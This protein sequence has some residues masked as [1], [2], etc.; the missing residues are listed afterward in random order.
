[1]AKP[2]NN[3]R[4]FKPK[5]RLAV[6]GNHELTIDAI[7]SDGRGIAKHK[8]KTVFVAGALPGEQ[9][10]V[11][12]TTNR[13]NHDEA[14][15]IK[16]LQAC[17]QRVAPP[18]QYYGRCGGCSF[19]H[20]HHEGQLQA[21]Q[22]H[23]QQLFKHHEQSQE[24]PIAWQPALSADAYHY[25]HRVRFAISAKGKHFMLGYRQANSHELIAID[26][27]A[28]ADPA[29]NTFLPTLKQLLSTL[30]KRALLLECAVA[31]DADKQ[32]SVLLSVKAELPEQDYAQLQRFAQPLAVTIKV[33]HVE[34]P[35]AAPLFISGSQPQRYRLSAD[36]N[37][38]YQAGDFTQINTAINQQMIQCLKSW[39]QL[40]EQDVVAD[41][42][43]GIGNL[44]LPMAAA[45]Q[46]LLAYELV[47]TMVAKAQANAADNGLTNITFIVADLFAE[48]LVIAQ[49]ANKVVL[50][51]PRAGAKQLCTVLAQHS[52][53][54]LLYI[55][56][57]PATL[58]RD[59]E[60][61]QQGGYVIS[62]AAL[63]DM[64]PQTKHMEC[65]LLLEKKP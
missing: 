34:Q 55:S 33:L 64:F 5:Q 26:S 1:M 35:Y 50:D 59:A 8:G 54:Q 13:K 25:R 24:Q 2:R 51:P 60:L 28:I 48:Q 10:L 52:A 12:F 45:S 46:Q 38:T 22:Q 41:Y 11:R 62:K 37:I 19:Q 23:L 56:C 6:Q 29:I 7:S 40:N 31:V 53:N 20:Y 58:A 61:L 32:L 16:V 14:E 57:N 4:I 3:L 36:M 15:T 39:L 9:V 30:S 43:C 27:C 17:E 21:K 44:T 47:E 65:M 49:S 63:I 18:C 42:F